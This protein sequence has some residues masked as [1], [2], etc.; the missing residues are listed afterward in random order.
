MSRR[1]IL[2]WEN[3]WDSAE[4]VGGAFLSPTALPNKAE[5]ED[6]GRRMKKEGEEDEHEEE[7]EEVEGEEVRRELGD[8]EGPDELLETRDFNAKRASV[9]LIQISSFG[10]EET[11]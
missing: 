2:Q 8:F 7:E 1:R 6:D 9:A 10:G 11:A 5:V 4:E 3:S